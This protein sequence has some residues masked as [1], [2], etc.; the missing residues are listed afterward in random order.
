MRIPLSW[1]REYVR[2]DAGTQEIADALSISTAEVNGVHRVGVSG[3]LG[4]FRVVGACKF[5]TKALLAAMLGRWQT[6]AA[7]ARVT[8]A[9]LAGVGGE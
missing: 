8:R 5:G 2:V 7:C 1:L 6:A 4:L 3:E 9:C